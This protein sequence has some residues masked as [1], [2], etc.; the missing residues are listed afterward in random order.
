MLAAYNR[1]VSSADLTGAPFSGAEAA[2]SLAVLR[3]FVNGLAL[4]ASQP[5]TER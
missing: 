4:P 1:L 5:S 2:D 3:D